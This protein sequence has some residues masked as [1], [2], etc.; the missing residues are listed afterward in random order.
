MQKCRI[1]V[2]ETT[3]N[4][5]LA[6]KYGVANLGRCPLHKVGQVFETDYAKPENFCNEAWIAIHHY[7]FALV[8]GS[9]IPFFCDK[10]IRKEGIS[11]NSCNDGFRPVLFKLERIKDNV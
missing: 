10:W 7:V 6:K 2:L 9:T 4:E 3:F 11:I 5:K 8:H 1:T